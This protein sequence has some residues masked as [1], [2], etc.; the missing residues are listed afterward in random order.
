[1]IVCL[2]KVDVPAEERAGFQAW[3]DENRAVR[4]GAGGYLNLDALTKEQ[5]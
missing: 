4:Q 5:P 2:R 1:M 3:I